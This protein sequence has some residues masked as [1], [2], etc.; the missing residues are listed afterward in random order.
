MDQNSPRPGGEDYP[1]SASQLQQLPA[2]ETLPHAEPPQDLSGAQENVSAL[3][4]S[5]EDS[6]PERPMSRSPADIQDEHI[7]NQTHVKRSSK[8]SLSAT[9]EIFFFVGIISIPLIV[10]SALLLGIVFIRRVPSSSSTLAQEPE[11][12]DSNVLRQFRCSEA[13]RACLT[14]EQC[15]TDTI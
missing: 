2:D 12:Q 13:P 1:G 3:D 10:L 15:R 14:F 11:Q 5:Q 8:R 6:E 4:P 9:A 7:A